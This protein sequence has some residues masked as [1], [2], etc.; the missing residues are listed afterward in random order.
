MF[1]CWGTL[2]ERMR[3]RSNRTHKSLGI[4]SKQDSG[5]DLRDKIDWLLC[6]TL[7]SNVGCVWPLCTAFHFY[8]NQIVSCCDPKIKFWKKCQCNHHLWHLI[9]W[10]SDVY[11]MLRSKHWP[12]WMLDLCPHCWIQFQVCLDQYVMFLSENSPNPPSLIRTI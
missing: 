11:Q 10:L 7:W 9:V 1:L 12:F 5:E 8:S 6:L 3:L 4:Y 2:V